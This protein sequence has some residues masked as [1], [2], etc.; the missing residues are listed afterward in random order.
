MA[1]RAWVRGLVWGLALALSGPGVVPAAC[2]AP[3]GS[4]DPAVALVF[5][6]GG[7]KGAWE[8][9]V[10]AALLGAGVPIRVAAG[11]S[12]GALN[13][14]MLADGRIDR[15]EALWRGV[16]RDQVYALRPGAF[17]AGLLPGWL[18]LL[19]LNQAG[20]LLDPE[21]LRQLI[22]DS[23]DLGRVRASPVRL[24]VVTS[25]VV[26]Y[27]TRIFDN[28]TVTLDALMAASAVPGAFPAVDVE[29]E[30][31][32]DGGLAGRAPIL[33]ALAAGVPVG[34]AVVAMS[35]APD[36]RASPPTTIRRALEGAFEMAMIHQ[37]LRDA[38]LARLKHPHV[39]VQ[40]L[41][42][43]AA[44]AIRP[45]DFDPV[46]LAQALA[47]GKR[48]GLACLESW[49]GAGGRDVSVPRR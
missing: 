30:L 9:G 6:G 39:D 7:A 45:L 31:L 22:A 29:G 8:A 26:R 15:L 19:T 33:E 12:A 21:P 14:A 10:A 36:D 23:L 49:K 16:T 35:Y 41:E 44:L 17:F 1:P 3:S 2:T 13:A 40:V 27:R 32:V 5:S 48:D 42:P 20:S 18:T 34:R 4:P 46:R 37:I 43:S 28:A 11:S 25:D 47:L 24:V 38:E